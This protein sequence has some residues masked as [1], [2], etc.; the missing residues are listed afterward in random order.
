MSQC[1]FIC[2]QLNGLK[3]CY[4]TI[5]IQSKSFV[6]IELNSFKYRK[7]LNISVWPIDENIT[8]TTTL[9]QSG[10]WSNGNKGIFHIFQS[11]KTEATPSNAV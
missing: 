11:S 10:L 2:T 5:V 9:G 1:S 6:C 8:S 7:G 4:L 3:Y